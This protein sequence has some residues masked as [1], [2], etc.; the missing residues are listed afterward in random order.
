M[1]VFA[2]ITQKEVEAMRKRVSAYSG[3]YPRLAEA[4]GV[5]LSTL[6]R[7]VNDP[8]RR[9]RRAALDLIRGYFKLVD[10]QQEAKK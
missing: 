9:P 6:Y 10:K 1:E 2:P 5:S 7:F 4:I 8:S 3:E